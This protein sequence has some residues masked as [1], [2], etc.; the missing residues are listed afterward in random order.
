MSQDLY[1]ESMDHITSYLHCIIS[2]ADDICIFG[3]NEKDHDVNMHKFMENAVK[4]WLV[5]NPEKHFVKVPQINFFSTV[6]MGLVLMKV[7]YTKSK[8]YLLLLQSRS[9]NFSWDDSIL[10]L[11]HSK[12]F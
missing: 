1:Q 6:K 5:F 7:A 11:F 3:E 9:Y 4:N 2:I 8:P 12:T 10:G